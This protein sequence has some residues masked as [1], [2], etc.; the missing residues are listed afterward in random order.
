MRL[1]ASLEHDEC[2][3]GS[4]SYSA[5]AGG[6]FGRR[7]YPSCRPVLLSPGATSA[8]PVRSRR[9]SARRSA[10]LCGAGLISPGHEC[11]ARRYV[12]QAHHFLC[13]SS[14]RSWPFNRFQKCSLR[15]ASDFDNRQNG[16]MILPSFSQW[17]RGKIPARGFWDR[18]GE[19]HAESGLLHHTCRHVGWRHDASR[20]VL[21]RF[22]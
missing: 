1:V 2:E 18:L 6:H 10:E 4:E 9:G 3:N 20:Y 17:A 13:G 19:K 5:S 21:G 14:C 12:I 22:Y 11:S 7:M 16:A 15:P 8:H